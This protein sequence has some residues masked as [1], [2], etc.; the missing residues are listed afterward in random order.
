M[1][2]DPNPD[3][4]YF[5]FVTRYCDDLNAKVAATQLNDWFIN[6]WCVQKPLFEL[7][8]FMN[9]HLG[10]PRCSKSLGEYGLKFVLDTDCFPSFSIPLADG[11]DIQKVS[12]YYYR[13]LYYDVYKCDVTGNVLY[14]LNQRGIQAHLNSFPQR[15]EQFVHTVKESLSIV[16]N[17]NLLQFEQ[18]RVNDLYRQLSNDDD[19][20]TKYA[21]YK[22]VYEFRCFNISDFSC[23][24]F[25][26]ASALS[27]YHDFITNDSYLFDWDYST[28][29]TKRL[30]CKQQYLDYSVHEEIKPFIRYFDFLDKLLDH[31]TE[32]RSEC[33]K[34]RFNE[35]A[36]LRKKHNQTKYNSLT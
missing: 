4:S 12:L 20:L 31:V 34:A 25:C 22:H 7:R 6:I 36:E 33:S 14:R 5:R 28:V 21:Y 9:E 18:Y 19:L 13:K 24:L 27:H 35:V 29:Y 16:S 32:Y 3:R 30:H 11:Y 26:P 8:K 23:N 1:T 10:K 2:N 15:I 17:Q